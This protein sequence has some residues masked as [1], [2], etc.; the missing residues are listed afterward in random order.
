MEHVNNI[1]AELDVEHLQNLGLAGPGDT[2]GFVRLHKRRLNRSSES[3][4]GDLDLAGLHDPKMAHAFSTI[5]ARLISYQTLLHIGLTSRR[6]DQLWHEW[7]N[8]PATGPQRETLPDE[9]EADGS[10]GSDDTGLVV[11]F[12]D[13]VLGR[14]LPTG[15]D[16][17]DGR[18]DDT[19]WTTCLDSCGINSGLREAIM[20]PHFRCIRHT[21][22]CLHW[23][24]DTVE[25]RYAGLHDIQRA[26]QQRAADVHTAPSNTLG[27]GRPPALV[28]SADTG[29][30][31]RRPQPLS[32]IQQA[33]EP[34]VSTR[35]WSRETAADVGDK[36]GHL[37]LYKGMDQG[38]LA[39][40]W[41]HDSGGQRNSGDD[42]D[43]DDG[44]G[45]WRVE[46]LL[47]F[48]PTNFSGRHAL[49]YFTPDA[50]V[51]EYYAA[52]AKRRTSCESVVI[53]ALTIKNEDLAALEDPDDETAAGHVFRLYY[54]S[55]HWKQ[56]VWRSRNAR[57]FTRP[58]CKYRDAL[59]LI[60][61]TTKGAPRVFEDM[62]SWEEM[63]GDNVLRVPDGNS[64]PAIQ[65]AFNG[66]DGSDFLRKKGQFA[67]FA[68][69]NAVAETIVMPSE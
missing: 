26:S 47:S 52:Y 46:K 16:D 40:F 12:L 39:G 1:L 66:E 43:D 24:V 23:L 14:L 59:L 42:D 20:D 7:E 63:S 54:P 56:V 25:M 62:E 67:V 68:L 51:A 48:P 50:R 49:F 34:G 30:S 36:P 28:R 65:Y 55:P 9:K 5:P 18:H 32:E 37:V 21:N 61:T 44:Y 19:A 53:V 10:G 8:W 57:S 69:S 11:P 60:G 29:L 58:L 15:T 33:A 41:R 27:T 38:R 64:I 2:P 22:S 17:A 35:R 13:F 31:H 6:A 3:E 45:N 4:H